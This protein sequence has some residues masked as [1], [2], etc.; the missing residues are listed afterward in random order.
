MILHQQGHQHQK[1]QWF[2]KNLFKH[3]NYSTTFK[4]LF[5]MLKK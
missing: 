3:N 4:F 1:K 2:L 5:N